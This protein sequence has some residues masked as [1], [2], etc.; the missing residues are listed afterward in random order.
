MTGTFIDS[1]RHT[2]CLR[3]ITL[4]SQTF[5]DNGQLDE[6]LITGAVVVLSNWN[7]MVVCLSLGVVAAGAGSFVPAFGLL[8]GLVGGVSQ[9]FL[10]F[11]LPPLMW[12]KQLQL[13]DPSFAVNEASSWACFGSLPWREK[14]LVLCGLG[15]IG[16]TLQSTWA[17][18]GNE[19]L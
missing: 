7:H 16:W 5:T 12:A 2:A 4:H 3:L 8:S 13:Q 15:L 10:A 19:E 9:T 11:V 6:K 18:L 1:T 17:E 14:A